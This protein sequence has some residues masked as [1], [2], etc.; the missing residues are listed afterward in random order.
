MEE[1]KLMGDAQP[2]YFKFWLVNPAEAAD[3]IKRLLKDNPLQLPPEYFGI[4]S[5]LFYIDIDTEN[6]EIPFPYE[7]GLTPEAICFDGNMADIESLFPAVDRAC[8]KLA[9]LCQQK[10]RFGLGRFAEQEYE[11]M[12]KHSLFTKRMFYRMGGEWILFKNIY[13]RAGRFGW[14]WNARA[15]WIDRT[16][17]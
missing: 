9:P 5:L 14:F 2:A 15:R 16:D 1:Q 3:T 4:Y 13:R 7:V 6:K 12:R 11:G 17:D 8:A 10:L